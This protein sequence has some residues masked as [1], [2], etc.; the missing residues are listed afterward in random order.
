MQTIP[1]PRYVIIG[2]DGSANSTAALERAAAE[3]QQRHARLDVV[4]VIPR[5]GG[6]LRM[7]AAWLRLRN[8][9]ARVL[10]RA[11]HITTRLR[12]ARGDAGTEL[13][14]LAGHAEVLVIGACLNTRHGTPLGGETVPAV[15]SAALCE[16][17]VCE[18]ETRQEV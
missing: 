11:R 13:P 16:V 7:P 3:A 18:G 2:F 17:I 4:R 10:P 5:A 8:E 14:R 15:L 12:I 9:V 1:R 6:L